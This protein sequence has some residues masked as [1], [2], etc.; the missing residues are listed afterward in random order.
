MA[1][2]KEKLSNL[3]ERI[4]NKLVN[5]RDL[6]REQR[7]ALDQAFKD[8][9][10]TGY[11][12]VAEMQAERNIARKDIAKDVRE[13]LAPLTPTSAFS[14]GVKRGTLVAAGDIVGSFA[15]YII[16]GKK[17]ASEARELAL[18]GKGV[19]Y[20]PKIQK[21]AGKNTFNAMSNLIT[22]LPGLRGIKAFQNTAKVLDGF[23]NTIGA[24]AT[25]QKLVTSQALRTE[26]KSQ[27]LGATGAGAGSVA[28]DV[29]NFPARFVAGANE[30]LAK[31]D[32]NQYNQ[33]SPLEKT[34]TLAVDNFRTALMWN[35]GAFGLGSALIG[36]SNQARKFFALNPANQQKLNNIINEKGL[37]VSP[38][39]AAEGIGGASGLF[40]SLNRILSVLPPAAGEPLRFK[41]KFTGA[42]LVGLQS[43]LKAATNV[44]L[45]H[46][47][48]LAQT[49]K[50]TVEDTYKKSSNIYGSLYR[51]SEEQ[52]DS[53]SNILNNYKDKIVAKYRGR[54]AQPGQAFSDRDQD[55]INSVFPQGTTIPF[56]YTKN[57][58]NTSNDIVREIS[59]G[60]V[61]DEFGR[62]K[63]QGLQ[64]ETFDPLNAFINNINE[65]L[66]I[67]RRE[68]GGDY[69]T[70]A[71][72]AKL[73]RDW[74]KNWTRT[75]QNS[76][77]E[78][79]GKVLRIQEAFE[80]DFNAVVSAPSAN[81]TLE[82]NPRLNN[83]YNTVRKELGQQEADNFL[84]A[85]KR[86]LTEA[87]QFYSTANG[88]FSQSVNFY[89]GNK[90]A[91]IMR[92]TDSEALSVR[93]ALN[94]EGKQPYTN[95]QGMNALFKAAFDANTG[96]KDGVRELYELLGGAQYFPKATQERARY[97]MNLLTYRKFFDAFNKNA[98][99]RTTP[100]VPGGVEMA[101]PFLA[102]GPDL[103][104]TIRILDERSPEFRKTTTELIDDFYKMGRPNE[105]VIP[106]LKFQKRALTPE[107]IRK[108]ID[109]DIGITQDV[110][111]KREVDTVG[112]AAKPFPDDVVSITEKA[113]EAVVGGRIVSKAEREAAQEQLEEIQL[114]LG[115]YQGFKFDKFA[116]DIGIDSPSGR[117]QLVEAFK[118]SKGMNEVAAKKHVENI[119]VIIDALKRDSFTPTGDASTYVTRAAIFALGA[120]A[121]GA[122]AG[123]AIGGMGGGVIGAIMGALALKYGAR[124]FNS[125]K[126]ASQWL[127]I[128]STGQ[129]LDK[130]LKSLIPPKRAVFADLFNTLTADDPDAPKIS[131][132]DIPEEE[133]IKYLQGET[134]SSVPTEEGLYEAIPQEVKE[135]FDPDLK[136]LRELSF[137]KKAE[138][139]SFNKGIKVGNMRTDIIDNLSN[140]PV[141]R[142][143]TPQVQQ[144]LESPSSIDVS[145]QSKQAQQA[146][147]NISGATQTVYK[148]LFPGDPLGEAIAGK[149]GAV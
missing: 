107:V 32:R 127:D 102:K 6:N 30:D 18:Q 129:R 120:G 98:V 26:L 135:K 134:L 136:K 9:V 144:F 70:P 126:M 31:I 88:V 21:T 73:S 19:S 43:N 117:E 81:M 140:Q 17:L 114:R 112:P 133:V 16:D 128:Y 20:I 99:V 7:A 75:F 105:S 121:G 89:H 64:S 4:D 15:P 83:F 34:Y 66:T 22:K 1:I 52:Y 72:F 12:S 79:Q 94:V 53:V 131:A 46:A 111:I 49:V 95:V 84:N 33:M 55:I 29:I 60:N 54:P 116:R 106:K 92:K 132:A 35:A 124:F 41:Q 74:N 82:A 119:E 50:G 104:E 27:A 8:K 100:G 138:I 2:S 69:L 130:N 109:D 44:P 38:I 91:A 149:T 118:I 48:V 37:P 40:K 123:I 139:E 145:Q 93:G 148:T 87:N 101:E 103:N 97:V 24:G 36:L 23:A 68:N 65:T 39:Q 115:G 63:A 113:R 62:L 61:G 146:Q 58:K 14:L 108:A 125:P 96:T 56:I 137:E 143:I 67:A 86:K 76:S 110:L 42:A 122:T 77:N 51:K 47:E 13:K 45:V 141:P 78:V 85:F 59:K 80:K 5:P 71:Q 25:A 142:E 147:A 10:L 57:L 90:L 11:G 28:F 3:Q